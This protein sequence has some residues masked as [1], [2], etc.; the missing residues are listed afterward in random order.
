MSSPNISVSEFDCDSIEAIAKSIPRKSL[1][2]SEASI[3]LTMRRDFFP[4]P[5]ALAIPGLYIDSCH[6][7]GYRMFYLE[8]CV[9]FQKIVVFLVI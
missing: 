5:I 3:L 6:H 2:H 7:L 8:P 9:E 4:Q 1:A